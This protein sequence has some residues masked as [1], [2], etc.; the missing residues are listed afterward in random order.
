MVEV[1]KINLWSQFVG[2]AYWDNENK[3][4]EFQFDPLFLSQGLNL[5]PIE[6]SITNPRLYFFNNLNRDTFYGLPGLLADAL[7]DAYGKVLLDRWLASNGRA[8]VNPI[9]RLCYQGRRSMGALEFEP[10]QDMYKLENSSALEISS[11]VDIAK[12]VLDKKSELNVNFGKDNLTDALTQVISIGTSAGGARAK[13]VIAYNETTKDVRSGQINAPDGYEHWLLKLDGVTNQNLG[14]PKQYGIIEYIYYLMARDAGIDM[15]D[16]RLLEENNRFHFMTKRFDRVGASEKLHT[17]T[18]CGIAHYDYKLL[19]AYS[20]E[21]LF[22]V[23]RKLRLSV[24]QAEEMYRRMVFNVIARN[25]DDHTKNTSF[26]MNKKGE[27]SLSPAYDI[28][29]SYNP[30]GEWTS[31]HQMSIMNKWDDFT[32]SDLEEF[33]KNINI[34]PYK[35]IIEQVREA[36]SKWSVLAQEYD[37]AASVIS[38]IENSF[39][40]KL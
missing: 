23:M 29:W 37:L 28:S 13:A 9:E 34:K 12:Q 17:Q 25:Q 5:S 27:W 38:E 8:E 22:Q 19:R 33:A 36:V 11:L 7:P 30:H 39:R 15:M 18:L 2:A 35:E 1:V 24:T 3:V 20:Y 32:Y 14:D 31:K 21:Q 40:L 10:A 6:M 4:A 26:I 16:C